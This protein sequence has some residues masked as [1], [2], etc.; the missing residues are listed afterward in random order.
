[1]ETQI[2]KIHTKIGVPKYNMK[3]SKKKK[4]GKGKKHPH[5]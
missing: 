4:F 2:L 1:M 5:Q 3:V